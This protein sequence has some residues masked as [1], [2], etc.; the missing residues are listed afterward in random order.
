MK[1]TIRNIK[2]LIQE[3]LHEKD[4]AM[5]GT[6]EELDQSISHMDPNSV[7]DKDYVDIDTGEIYLEKGETAGT[8]M[9]HPQHDEDV[10]A[11]SNLQQ[12]LDDEEY[13]DE[14]DELDQSDVVQNV[15][16]EFDAAVA[17]FA[18]SATDVT[19]TYPD[20]DPAGL[21]H[22]LADGFFVQYPR[23]RTWAS[24]MN[25]SKQDMQS[26]VAEMAY[27]AVVG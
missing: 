25:M 23:W 24:L 7:A 15:R 6:R 9:L 12:Q 27:E 5:W 14:E 17:E 4:G 18:A 26:Y 21:M 8:S 16:A 3:A 11:Y 1:T 2:R 13:A 19:S 20:E 22:D 10:A